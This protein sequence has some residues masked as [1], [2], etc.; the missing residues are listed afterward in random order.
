[1]PDPTAGFYQHHYQELTAQK[2]LETLDS[3]L[4]LN[5]F[6]ITQD[7]HPGLS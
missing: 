1:M 4:Q 3:L 5:K 7:E 6:H 2:L